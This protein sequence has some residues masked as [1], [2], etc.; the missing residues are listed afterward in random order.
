LTFIIYLFT[1]P[2]VYACSA[3]LLLGPIFL[4]LPILK[5]IAP[6]V[7]P[8]IDTAVGIIGIPLI[9]ASC[10]ISHQTTKRVAY[11]HLSLVDSFKDTFMTLK[12]YVKLI[13]P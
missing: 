4:V 3:V 6:G 10:W 11:W 9:A 7:I 12:S 13:L 5:F 2:I 8:F 1:W